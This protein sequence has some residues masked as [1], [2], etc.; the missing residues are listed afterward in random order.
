M[1]PVSFKLLVAARAASSQ[2][3]S[4]FRLGALDNFERFDFR[5]SSVC[6]ERVS[7]CWV[8]WVSPTLC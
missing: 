5:S 1:S 4:F 7:V 3:W 2:L 6:L 8:E